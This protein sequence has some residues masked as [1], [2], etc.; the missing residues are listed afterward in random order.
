MKNGMN[1]GS[2]LDLVNLPLVKLHEIKS[3]F[4]MT[5]ALM[6][7]NDVTMLWRAKWRKKEISF[8]DVC[9]SNIANQ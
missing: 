1:T 2:S 9:Q 4:I 7:M 8:V 3:I 5:K 6:T